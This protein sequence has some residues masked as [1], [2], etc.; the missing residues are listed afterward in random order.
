MEGI[1]DIDVDGRIFAAIDLLGMTV[2]FKDEAIEDAVEVVVVVVV[3]EE[4]IVWIED[5]DDVVVGSMEVRFALVV[6]IRG[7]R[8]EFEIEVVVKGEAEVVVVFIDKGVEVVAAV[9]V[10]F[11]VVVE[12]VKGTRFEE[13]LIGG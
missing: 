8:A 4:E 3:V 2:F 6:V 12:G 11:V 10:V 9:V 1:A 7:C 13:E 5:V